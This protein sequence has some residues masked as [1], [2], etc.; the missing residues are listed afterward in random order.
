VDGD[1]DVEV[2]FCEFRKEWVAFG[3][4][5]EGCVVRLTQEAQEG[6]N[7]GNMDIDIHAN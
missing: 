4:C 2:S 5:F 7:T 3:A 1:A 6:L